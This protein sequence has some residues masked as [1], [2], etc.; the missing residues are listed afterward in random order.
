MTVMYEPLNTV[1]FVCFVKRQT[2]EVWNARSPSSGSDEQNDQQGESP[3]YKLQ[4]L[5]WKGTLKKE[6]L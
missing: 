3:T 6:T 4:R 1:S 2:V 5:M